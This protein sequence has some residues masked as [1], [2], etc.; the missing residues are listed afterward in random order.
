MPRRTVELEGRG[1]GAP[2]IAYL[3]TEW[4][5]ST[6]KGEGKTKKQKWNWEEWKEP[7]QATQK[8]MLAVF[9]R[10]QVR[11]LISNHLSTIDGK[12]FLQLR[13]GPIG[14]RITTVLARMVMFL[15]DREFTEITLRLGLPLL[16]NKRYVD[17]VNA[18][19]K[20]LGEED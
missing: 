10:K 4:Y 17:D 15:F 14:E 13:G 1:R 16:L 9:L 5:I 6:T 12:L 8:M 18:A 20:R 3:D 19:S 11:V 2:T 7:G